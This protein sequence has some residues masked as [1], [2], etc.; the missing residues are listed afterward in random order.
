MKKTVWFCVFV[1]LASVGQNSFGTAPGEN[2]PLPPGITPVRAPNGNGAG[3]CGLNVIWNAVEAASNMSATFGVQ[4][5]KLSKSARPG[6]EPELLDVEFSNLFGRPAVLKAIENLN[7]AFGP[8]TARLLEANDTKDGTLPPNGNGIVV[9]AK[10]GNKDD[11][12]ACSDQ[13]PKCNYTE[14]PFIFKTK[15]GSASYCMGFIKCTNASGQSICKP[16]G[17]QGSACPAAEACAN[18]PTDFQVVQPTLDLNTKT[19]PI[20]TTR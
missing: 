5:F 7:R 17:P 18:D 9:S 6:G 8:G 13:F 15:N 16:I 1:C 4:A 11:K 3:Q 12:S 2:M 14:S 20:E 10:F 19:T